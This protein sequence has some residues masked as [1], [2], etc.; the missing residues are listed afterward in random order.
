MRYKF[1]K[2]KAERTDSWLEIG[3]KISTGTDDQGRIYYTR[4][5]GDDRKFMVLFGH[6]QNQKQDIEYLKR[7]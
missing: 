7:S 6:K 1:A 3:K 4:T 2:K 5:G